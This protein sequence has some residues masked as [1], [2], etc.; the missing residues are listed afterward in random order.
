MLCYAMLC[1]VAF[2]MLFYAILLVSRSHTLD[3]FKYVIHDKSHNIR[4]SE[5]NDV[6]SVI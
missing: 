5:H 4:H 6:D 2:F 1:Y 3:E